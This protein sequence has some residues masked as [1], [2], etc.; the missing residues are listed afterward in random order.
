MQRLEERIATAESEGAA[1]DEIS[2]ANEALKLGREL[3][4]PV[5]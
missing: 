1:E 5:A 4:P 2:K 3:E